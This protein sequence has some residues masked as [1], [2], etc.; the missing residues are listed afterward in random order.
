MA[1]TIKSTFKSKKDNHVDILEFE[2]YLR[3][4]FGENL[5]NFQKYLDKGTLLSITK[6]GPTGD[7]E[8]YYLECIQEWVDGDSIAEY[9]KDKINEELTDEELEKTYNV[10]LTHERI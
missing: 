10:I 3:S 6:E 4:I 9:N 5:N 7:S 2:Q 1:V 8:Y